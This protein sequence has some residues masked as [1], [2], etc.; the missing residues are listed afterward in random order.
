MESDRKPKIFEKA[1]AD[2]GTEVVSFDPFKFMRTLKIV[3]LQGASWDADPG[4]IASA[5][6]QQ[7]WDINLSPF[8]Y[9]SLSITIML[10]AF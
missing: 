4:K 8:K 10:A 6:S 9:F 2:L 3:V 7:E 1:A 5:I